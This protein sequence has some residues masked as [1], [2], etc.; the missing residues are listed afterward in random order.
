MQIDKYTIG[1]EEVPR[2][3]I[4][5][6]SIPDGAFRTYLILRIIADGKSDIEVSKDEIT[7]D[8]NL[9]FPTLSRQLEWLNEHGFIFINKNHGHKNIYRIYDL[10][11]V[12]CEG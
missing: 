9:S 6:K 1:V 8:R 3:L 5:D 2:S 12:Y 4:L 7:L 11:D 10:K